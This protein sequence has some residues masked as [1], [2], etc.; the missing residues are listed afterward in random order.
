MFI[1]KLILLNH[2][3]I[4]DTDEALKQ[5]PPELTETEEAV[6]NY[7]ERDDGLTNEILDS[8]LGILWTEETFK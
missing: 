5:A 3:F 2:Y 8:V 4:R 1:N 6:K 7:L